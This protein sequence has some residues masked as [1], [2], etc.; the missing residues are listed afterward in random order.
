MFWETII[1]AVVVALALVLIVPSIRIVGP[2]RIGLVIKRFSFKKLP[3]DDPI[4]FR[5]EAGF[6]ADLLMPGWRFKFWILYRVK[7]HPWVQIPA[8]RI[9]VVISQVGAPLPTG[10]KSAVYRPELGNFSNERPVFMAPVDNHFITYQRLA[11][12][13]YASE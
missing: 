9:G 2:T 11:A 4:A 6:Q 10:A 8:G 12:R 13:V 5:G 7:M 3:G 1:G